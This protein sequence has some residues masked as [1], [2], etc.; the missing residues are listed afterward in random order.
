MVELISSSYGKANV[1]FLKVKKDPSNPLIQDVL[2]ANV[3]VLLKGKFDESYTKADNSSIVPT[4]T[5]KN[6]ILVEAKN[7]NVWPIESFAAHLAKHFTSKYSQVEG[8]EITIIQALWN[9]IKLNGKS[10]EHSFKHEGPETR[11]TQLTYDKLSKKLSLVSSIKDL[12]VLKSTGS[13]FYGYNVCDY[14]TLQPTKD[15]I[16][17]TDVDASWSYKVSNLDEIISN[18]ALFDKTYKSARDITLELFCKEN[19][20]SVQ[21]T[22]YNMG[23]K[24]IDENKEVENVTYILPNKH[25]ILFNFEWKGIKDNKEL[26]YPSPDPNGLIKC[27]IGREKAKL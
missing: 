15:R 14:T 18:G 20:P 26:F 8:I 1:K 4:D 16:L 27:T 21:A 9:K 2:E 3:Q 11:R 24:I 6:T 7:N 17:S 22:M 23:E 10:H 19:S 5:V 25:Y 12:T 13:M